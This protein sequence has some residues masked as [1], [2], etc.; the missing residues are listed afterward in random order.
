VGTAAITAVQ[1]EGAMVEASRLACL[2]CQLTGRRKLTCTR[3]DVCRE[4]PLAFF[5]GPALLVAWLGT[6]VAF[7]VTVR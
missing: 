5:L 1:G 6:A 2:Q 3:K 4:L 7:F